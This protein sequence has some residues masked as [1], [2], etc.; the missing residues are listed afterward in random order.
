MPTFCSVF[1]ILFILSLTILGGLYLRKM[2][3][4]SKKV[5]LQKPVDINVIK[6]SVSVSGSLK[7]K[8]IV[9]EA[10]IPTR[11]PS[12]GSSVSSSRHTGLSNHTHH[13]TS[14]DHMLTGMV[15]GSAL[16]PNSARDADRCAGG[17]SSPTPSYSSDSGSGSDSGGSSCSG[18]SYD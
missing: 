11:S 18:G 6:S 13:N 16:S 2:S 1:L 5:S 14:N 15:V 10:M 7:S 8:P 3:K 4:K 9:Q 17:Y 12:V